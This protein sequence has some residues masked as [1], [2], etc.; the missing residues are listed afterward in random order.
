MSGKRHSSWLSGVVCLFVTASVVHAQKPAAAE[1]SAAPTSISAPGLPEYLTALDNEDEPKP[2]PPSAEDQAVGSEAT[3]A[4]EESQTTNK[5]VSPAVES[6]SAE[7]SPKEATVPANTVS[8]EQWNALQAN[9]EKLQTAIVDLNRK[10]DGLQKQN[11][12][13][14]QL[15]DQ[16]KA[17]E[18]ANRDL[19][20]ELDTLSTN[21]PTAT[22]LTD[23]RQRMQLRRALKVSAEVRLYNWTETNARM[24]VNGTWHELKPG[25]NTIAV[26]YGPVTMHRWTAGT[27][28]SFDNWKEDEDAPYMA[29]DVGVP[30]SSK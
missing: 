28:R 8:L 18:K 16:I 4:N 20:D 6:A 9:L 3:T 12:D 7:E 21:D 1:K 5:T 2:K 11:A 13:L 19:R 17:L 25:L 23:A 30:P 29:F 26:P 10:V 14:V 22:L 15:Q 27:P 24:N